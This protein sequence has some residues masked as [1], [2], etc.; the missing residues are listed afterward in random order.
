[1]HGLYGIVDT[2]A[3]P[4]R[5]HGELAAAFLAAGV[6]TL[7][8]RM[9]GAP[10]ADVRVVVQ[11]LL[12]S[13]RANGATL[14]LNDHVALAA[15]FEGV[16]AHIGQDDL[17]PAAARDLLGPDRIL[18]WSTHSPDDVRR[19]NRLPV[20]YIGFGPVFTAATK[21]LRP[22]DARPALQARGIAGLK[23]AL[24]VATLPLVAIGG[25]TMDNVAEVVSAGAPCV[26]V[27]SA[28]SAA[29]DPPSAARALQRHFPR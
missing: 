10:E 18:G 11:A 16:G 9:K 24:E 13:I 20:D 19:A 14:I 28:V 5:T 15:T 25:I 29:P 26:A 12:P 7:Q 21:H 1:M 17:D 22:D 8:L 2:S 6:R 3:S 23:A 4:A 27:I